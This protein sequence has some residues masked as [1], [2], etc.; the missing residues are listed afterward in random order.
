MDAAR[1]KESEELL[2]FF[3]SVFFDDQILGDDV[4][5]QLD[6]HVSVQFYLHGVFTK[7]LNRRM[8]VNALLIDLDASFDEL[9]V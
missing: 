9:G 3:R 1:G 2:R 6:A 7:R 8:Q 4:E 5:A